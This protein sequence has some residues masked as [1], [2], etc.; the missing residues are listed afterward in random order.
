MGLPCSRGRQ[1]L[2]PGLLRALL[3]FVLCVFLLFP[4]TPSDIRS[5]M[6]SFGACGIGRGG[7][8]PTSSLSRLLGGFM[9]YIIYM[10]IYER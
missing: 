6:L 8:V 9:Y 10:G 1:P 7:W 3:S 5:L 4:D 2:T